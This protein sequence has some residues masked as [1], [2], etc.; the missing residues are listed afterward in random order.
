M[1]TN[2]NEKSSIEQVKKL[3]NTTSKSV[4]TFLFAPNT[5]TRSRASYFRSTDKIGSKSYLI[6]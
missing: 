6:Q 4:P 3:I 1:S 5:S 2:I